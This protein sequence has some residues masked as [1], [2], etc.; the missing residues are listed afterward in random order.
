MVHNCASGVHSR[1]MSD[2]IHQNAKLLAA[3]PYHKLKIIKIFC[4]CWCD[5]TTNQNCMLDNCDECPRMD[6]SRDTSLGKFSFS[7]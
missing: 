7:S 4:L 5:V 2:E 1:F 6:K 3:A